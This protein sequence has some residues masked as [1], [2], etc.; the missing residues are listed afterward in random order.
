MQRSNPNAEFGAAGSAVVAVGYQQA[1]VPA[2]FDMMLPSVSYI[3]VG[4]TVTFQNRAAYTPHTVTFS[5]GDSLPGPMD[6]AAGTPTQPSGGSWSG[7]GLLNSGMLMPGADYAVT[8]TAAGVYDYACLMHPLMRGQIAVLPADAPIPSAEEQARAAERQ[9]ADA[10]AQAAALIAGCRVSLPTGTAGADG[11]T[12]WD[13]TAGTGA[14]GFDVEQ[15]Y[16]ETLL[17]SEGDSVTFTNRNLYEPHFVTFPTSDADRARFFHGSEPDFAA[18]MTPMG[19]TVVDGSQ[20]VNAGGIMPGQSVTFQFPK[21]GQYAYDCYLH[22]GNKM[23]GVIIVQPRGAVH[24]YMNG[25]PF[26]DTLI[27]PAEAGS[28]PADGVRRLGEALAL[29]LAL[30]GRFTYDTATRTLSIEAR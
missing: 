12:A 20:L 4:D 9:Q 8:F 27:R 7:R 2:S 15:Y 28:A 14:A 13:V 22:D 17:V 3:H 19:G 18:L 16:P 30:G 24:I 21:A 29:A 23:D 6:P 11:A 26:A 5:G 1:A 10:A 25:E